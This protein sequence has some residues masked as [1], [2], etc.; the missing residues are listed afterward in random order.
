MI[1]KCIYGKIGS[2]KQTVKPLQFSL[3]GA[4]G[5][6]VNVTRRLGIYAEPGVAYFFD[7]GSDM[8]TIR[9]ETPL[10]FNIQAGL[11]FTY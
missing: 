6:Q 8:Q 4:I 2:E 11:R 10:N 3:T 7:D 5:A 1:E 9:K